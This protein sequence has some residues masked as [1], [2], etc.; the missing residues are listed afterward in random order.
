MNGPHF[1]KNS[2][3][4]AK[5]AERYEQMTPPA[6]RSGYERINLMMDLTAADGVNGNRPIDW[7][8][9]IA[10]D[11]FNFLHDI[12]GIS[13]HVDRTTGHLGGCF[14]PRHTLPQA[15]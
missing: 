11:D 15:A 1:S 7:D 14:L 3:Q 9:L 6:A 8:R 4:A 13:R 12:G 5:A 10:A 2:D